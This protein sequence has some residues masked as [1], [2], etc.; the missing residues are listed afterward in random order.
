M[1]VSICKYTISMLYLI[2]VSATGMTILGDALQ[3]TDTSK[4][5]KSL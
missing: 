5:Y 2:H 3:K 4:Y 1:H